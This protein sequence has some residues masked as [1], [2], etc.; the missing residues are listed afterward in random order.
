MFK[1]VFYNI[2][3]AIQ[4][5]LKFTVTKLTTRFLPFVSLQ[6]RCRPSSEKQTF[7]LSQMNNAKLV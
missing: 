2:S 7:S 1:D 6:L 5:Q 4:A 3:L